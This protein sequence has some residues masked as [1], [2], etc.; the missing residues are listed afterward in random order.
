MSFEHHH[1]LSGFFE[2]G[3]EDDC[4]G[5]GQYYLHPQKNI[6]TDKVLEIAYGLGVQRGSV[7]SRLGLFDHR[8]PP[9]VLRKNK[10]QYRVTNLWDFQDEDQVRFFQEHSASMKEDWRGDRLLGPTVDYYNFNIYHQDMLCLNL[11]GERQES[12]RMQIGDV[13][14][15]RNE[16]VYVY[17][18]NKPFLRC[19]DFLFKMKRDFGFSFLVSTHSKMRYDRLD[20]FIYYKAMNIPKNRYLSIE[21]LD[22]NRSFLNIGHFECYDGICLLMPVSYRMSFPMSK[23]Q[24][25]LVGEEHEDRPFWEAIIWGDAYLRLPWREPF[26]EKS[27]RYALALREAIGC[28]IFM[29]EDRLGSQRLSELLIGPFVRGKH[30]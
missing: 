13:D 6:D 9:D 3:S 2:T 29:G 25:M 28:D 4:Q 23:A 19:Y 27:A 5:S 12:D 22:W 17:L 1:S 20:G 30:Y 14:I 7:Q 8:H 21:K 11:Y 15:I 10:D 16:A 24:D 26:I 18:S